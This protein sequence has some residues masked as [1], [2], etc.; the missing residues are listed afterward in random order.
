VV[1]FIVLGALGYAGQG[2][3]TSS[4]LGKKVNN[5]LSAIAANNAMQKASDRL[6]SE[7]SQF[8][9]TSN[10]C[11][12]NLSCAEAA[13]AKAAGYFSEFGNAVRTTSMP[14]DASAAAGKLYSDSMKLASDYTQLSHATGADQYEALA[15][16]GLQQDSDRFDEDANALQNVLNQDMG[17]R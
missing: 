9:S 12:H 17:S 3:V 16:G 15:T 10:A 6:N 4:T 2:V 14:A 13:D 1:L 5:S 11:G 8:Q 7:V